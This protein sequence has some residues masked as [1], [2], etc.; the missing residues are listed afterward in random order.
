MD[1]TLTD[2]EIRVMYQDKQR[3]PFPKDKQVMGAILAIIIILGMIA[4][5]LCFWALIFHLF[6]GSSLSEDVIYTAMIYN[7]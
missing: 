2:E 6:G 4:A 1:Q 5:G 3:E 7:S